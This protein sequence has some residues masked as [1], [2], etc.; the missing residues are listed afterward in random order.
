M[1]DVVLNYVNYS[2]NGEVD[3]IFSMFSDLILKTKF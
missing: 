1:K 2:E 3:K